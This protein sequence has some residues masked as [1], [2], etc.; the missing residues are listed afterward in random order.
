M[1]VDSRKVDGRREL[2]FEDFEDVIADA[3]KLV[4]SPATKMLGNW[5]LGRVLAH[6]AAVINLS[7]D[8]ISAKAPWRARLLGPFLKDRILNEEMSPGFNLPS[9]ALGEFYPAATSTEA[10]LDKLRSA[11]CRL[12]HERMSA[13]HPIFGYLSHEEWTLLH[14]RH[15]ELHL[16]FAIPREE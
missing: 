12:E 2:T 8:G 1:T 4:S 7:I 15:A 10:A 5:P 3:E 14:L 11:V 6:L 9:E 16:S 13:H